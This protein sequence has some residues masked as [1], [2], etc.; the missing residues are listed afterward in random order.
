MPLANSADLHQKVSYSTPVMGSSSQA[1]EN[2]LAHRLRYFVLKLQVSASTAT[3][4]LLKIRWDPVFWEAP[5]YSDRTK[6]PYTAA[7]L[8]NKFHEHRQRSNPQT[9]VAVLRTVKHQPLLRLGVSHHIQHGI[10]VTS[11]IVNVAPWF[12]SVGHSDNPPKVLVTVFCSVSKVSP[13]SRQS[14]SRRAN[15]SS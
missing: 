11:F 6:A 4:D 15:T 14:A 10:F 12:G 2:A 1:F 7:V 5:N 9:K 8:F 13:M 3:A